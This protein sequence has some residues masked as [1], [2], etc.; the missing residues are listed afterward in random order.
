MLQFIVKHLDRLL[1]KEVDL[2][3]NTTNYGININKLK[4][5]TVLLY[6]LGCCSTSYN[7]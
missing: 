7:F 1:K 4:T 2:F 5:S 6:Q 3:M